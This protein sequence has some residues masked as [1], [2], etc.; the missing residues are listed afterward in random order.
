MRLLLDTNILIALTPQQYPT[1]ASRIDTAI[2]S[3]DNTLFVSVASLWEVAIKT[4]VGR[5]DTGFSPV[6]FAMFVD[7]LPLTLLSIGRDHVLAELDPEPETRDPF[8]RLLLAQ[9]QVEGLRLVTRDR[10]LGA[11]PLA[12][13]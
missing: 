8:D 6:E 3:P 10:V 11:H 5:L 2:R 9:C 1:L 13:R 12:W 7:D 4:R